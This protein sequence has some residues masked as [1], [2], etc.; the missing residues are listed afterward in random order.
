LKKNLKL[1]LFSL[2]VCLALSCH[3]HDKPETATT[4]YEAKVVT[5]LQGKKPTT[6]PL[7]AANVDLL[8]K[9][10]DFSRLT[11]EESYKGEKLIIVPVK[12][13]FKEL[14][15]VNSKVIA[16]LV[17]KL[18]ASG[19]IRDGNL[20]LYTPKT[21]S[22][23]IPANTFYAIFNTSEP[24]CDGEF[25]FLSVTGRRLYEL[26]Y[27]SYKLSKARNVVEKNGDGVR[28]ATEQ[29]CTDWYWVTT[30][31]YTD[32]TTSQTWDY[33]TTTCTGCDCGSIECDCPDDDGSGNNGSS[34]EY[35]EIRVCSGTYIY[36]AH[37]FLAADGGG[38][39]DLNQRLTG[40]FHKIRSTNDYIASCNLVRSDVVN[41]TLGATSSVINYQKTGIGTKLVNVTTNGEVSWPDDTYLTFNKNY[42]IQIGLVGWNCN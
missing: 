25:K 8:S 14:K 40:R 21:E 6:Q 22:N 17:I 38:R 34:Y 7:K 16:T 12:E 27:E 29:V 42:Q 31:Y 23:I 41:N 11:V 36:L 13:R 9:N 10:L 4:N 18:A 2:P 3:K 33:M 30:T 20:V 26:T 1:L 35:E 24:P 15:N 39:L 28:D 37:T 5:W 32:G 19:E